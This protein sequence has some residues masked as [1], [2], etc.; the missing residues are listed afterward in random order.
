MQE[1]RRKALIHASQLARVSPG[2]GYDETAAAADAAAAHLLEFMRLNGEFALGLLL[3]KETN[4]IDI[5]DASTITSVASEAAK[6]Q[7]AD[8]SWY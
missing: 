3:V 5:D 7:F 1:D 6:K 2:L 4:H 8:I